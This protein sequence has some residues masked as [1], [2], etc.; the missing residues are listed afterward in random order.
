MPVASKKSTFL[1]PW[2]S[3]KDKILS[4]IVKIFSKIL[5]WLKFYPYLCSVLLL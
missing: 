1:I 2:D 3:R 5:L 4:F